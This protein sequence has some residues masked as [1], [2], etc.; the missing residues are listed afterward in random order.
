MPH[1]VTIS[2]SNHEFVVEDDESVLEGALREGFIIAYGCRNGACGTCKG[3]ILEGAVDYGTTEA[4][5]D[6]DKANGYALFCQARPLGDL[7]IE[8]REV[9]AVKDIQV[10]TLPCSVQHMGKLA[11]DVMRLQLK[12]PGNERLQYLA[13]QYLDI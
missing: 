10:R 1:R 7:V 2:P 12:L 6:E 4:L 9:S 11:P 8:C 13:G 5:T 3:K